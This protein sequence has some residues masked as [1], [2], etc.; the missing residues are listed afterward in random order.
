MMAGLEV[1][2]RYAVAGV[3]SLREA[4]GRW[5]RRAPVE[6]SPLSLDGLRE[7]ILAAGVTPGRDLLVH[8]SWAGLPIRATPREVVA[9][10]RGITG[11]RAT[12]LMP[13]HPVEKTRDDGMV[14]YDLDKSATRMGLLAE[15]MR[16]AP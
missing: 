5:A 10:L 9:M 6:S 2:G 15:S 11:E 14:V 3:P 8:S 16:R 4:V 1:V 7:A 13:A 12:L